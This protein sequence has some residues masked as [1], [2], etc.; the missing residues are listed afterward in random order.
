MNSSA[1]TLGIWSN[2]GFS[3]G[4]RKVVA[5]STNNDIKRGYYRVDAALRFETNQNS[6]TI[7]LPQRLEHVVEMHINEYIVR[8]PNGGALTPDIWKMTFPDM[9]TPNHI[10]NMGTGYPFA[11]DNA[12]LTHVVYDTPRVVSLT[13]KGWITTLRVELTALNGPAQFADATFWISFICKNGSW[14]PAQIMAADIA[15]PKIPSFP[16][17]GRQPW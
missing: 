15:T 9:I 12:T 14:D 7:T 16:F 8:T 13:N 10:S 17:D 11:I 6:V 1:S 4:K 5:M 2:R 3:G